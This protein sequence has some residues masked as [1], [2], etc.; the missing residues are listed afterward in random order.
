MKIKYIFRNFYK[1]RVIL[2]IKIIIASFLLFFII[3]IYS[4]YL[5]SVILI[6]EFMK[7]SITI[8]NLKKIFKN[9]EEINDIIYMFEDKII[10]TSKEIYSINKKV[11][12]LKY[13]DIVFLNYIVFKNMYLLFDNA[14]FID[15]K[16]IFHTTKKRY[17]VKC[18]I[19]LN[20]DEV[21][22]IYNII[23]K[24]NPNVETKKD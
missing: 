22:N 23:K 6:Y 13:D 3:G 19:S 10:L 14:S 17:V 15:T 8:Y 9:V 2:L 21:I 7:L 11:F 18:G 20:K 24:Y 16:L 4:F 5:F 12:K 1:K